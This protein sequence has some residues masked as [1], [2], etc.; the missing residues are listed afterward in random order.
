[1]KN[2]QSKIAEA[3]NKKVLLLASIFALFIAMLSVTFSGCANSRI[4]CI[5]NAGCNGACNFELSIEVD[6]LALVAQY[7]RF[8]NEYIVFEPPVV[9]AT[10]TNVSDREITIYRRGL[11]DNPFILF[12]PTRMSWSSSRD[13]FNVILGT[14]LE[15][16]G[17]MKR[18]PY[19]YDSGFIRGKHEATVL[20]SFYINYRRT[21]SRQ[22]IRLEYTFVFEVI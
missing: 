22:Q 6:G 8:F 13:P 11:D 16:N 17:Y 15:I 21:R 3:K 7:D 19:S 1:M 2:T 20:A 14:M 10:L 9:M 4:G 12:V 18:V 5:C